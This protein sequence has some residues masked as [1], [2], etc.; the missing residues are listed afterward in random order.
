MS[1]S[2]NIV[3]AR[4]DDW[5]QWVSEIQALCD[6][7]IWPHIDPDKPAPERG[8]E[9][10]PEK[11]TVASFDGNAQTYAQLNAAMQ[12]RF[13]QARKHFDQ[14][15]KYYQ[16][17]RDLLREVR[18]YVSSH[19]SAPKKLL[20][21]RNLTVREWLVKL[22]EDTEPT[23]NYM[24]T[25]VHNLYVEAMKGLGKTTKINQW[26]DKWEHAMKLIEKYRLPQASNGLWL[27]DLAQVIRPL[28]DTMC[29]SRGEL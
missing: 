17:Q 11:P 16:R 24:A 19:V 27:R 20:L 9:T 13:D 15:L 18:K 22:K 23:E 6:E 2:E 28:S 4:P 26:V 1:A 10:E 7:D 14:D 12:N 21:E 5:E 25:K 3:L 8:L 29:L